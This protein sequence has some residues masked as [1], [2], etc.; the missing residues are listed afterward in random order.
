M[1]KRQVT[2]SLLHIKSDAFWSKITPSATTVTASSSSVANLGA[3]QTLAGLVFGAQSG[4]HCHLILSSHRHGEF[5]SGL[6]CHPMRSKVPS[7]TSMPHFMPKPWNHWFYHRKLTLF[8]GHQL[9][10]APK[11]I[12]WGQKL[13]LRRLPRRPLH[14]LSRTMVLT[15][16]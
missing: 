6:R 7:D 14:L 8:D 9:T 10:F 12:H 16:L 2:T 4:R 13:H 15:R 5:I 1:Y 11:I 3:H